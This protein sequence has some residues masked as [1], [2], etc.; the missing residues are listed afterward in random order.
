PSRG[1]LSELQD[2][3][4][5]DSV[6][7]DKEARIQELSFGLDAAR[8]MRRTLRD[9]ERLEALL[10]DPETS[11]PVRAEVERELIE[12]YAYEKRHSWKVRD[13]AARAADSVGH[14]L[15]RLYW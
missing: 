8:A 6:I 2:R 15:S 3:A 12:L 9:Q 4:T 11:E 1:A 13:S 7:L 14:A 5:G 10:E